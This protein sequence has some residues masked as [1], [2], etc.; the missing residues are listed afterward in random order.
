MA[1]SLEEIASQLRNTKFRKKRLGGLD[2]EDVWRKLD[3]LQAEYAELI[4]HTAAGSQPAAGL[5]AV[6]QAVKGRRERAE[7]YRSIRTLV[8]KIALVIV[9]AVTVLGFVFGIG[10]MRGEGMYPRMRDGDFVVY[11]R[12]EKEQEIGDIISFLIDGK[13]QFARVV[14]RSGDVVDMTDGGQLIVNGNI[15]EEEVFFATSK[16]GKATV[17]PYT[18]E[19]EAV[20]VLCDN[21]SSTF[22]G[23]DYGTIHISEIDGKVITILR[24]RGL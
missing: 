8:V 17:F 4:K 1:K 23:R 3:R 20:F 18:V 21:R 10:I 24:R 11:Y 19:D 16:E 2:E 6:Q 7:L 15:Q 14:A 22:D 5:A 9:A 12:L 13:R